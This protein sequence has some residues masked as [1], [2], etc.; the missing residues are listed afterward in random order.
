MSRPDPR[1]IRRRP[2][3]RGAAAFAIREASA[4]TGAPRPLFVGETLDLHM[5]HTLLETAEAMVEG[6][7]YL[8]G[9][10]QM[11]SGTALLDLDLNNVPTQPR[12]P[13]VARRLARALLTDT[14]VGPIVEARAAAAMSRLLGART[15]GAW[16]SSFR[17]RADGLCVRL[18]VEMEA[19]LHAQPDT[20]LGIG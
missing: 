11:F 17:A 8:E 20:E 16:R 6:A 10:E 7:S 9:T 5:L 12:A 13:A 19:V 18:D 2:M 3:A 4:R 15:P 14:R 1:E